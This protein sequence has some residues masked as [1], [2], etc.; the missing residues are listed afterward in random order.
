MAAR[1]VAASSS[2]V[3]VVGIPP[4]RSVQN[5]RAEI[6]TTNGEIARIQ[7]A[8]LPIDELE[9]SLRTSLAALI[10]PA[11][12]L[13]SRAAVLL[14]EGTRRVQAGDLIPAIDDVDLRANLALGFALRGIGVDTLVAEARQRA[15]LGASLRLS[16]GERESR[17][18]ELRR[19][20]YVLECEDV[21]FSEAAGIPL[22]ADTNPAAALGVPAEI[23]VKHGLL[24]E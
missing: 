14:A 15:D 20:R 16:R 23:A 9:S 22:R 24:G 18:G 11:D 13:I 2:P 1:A 8:A 17:I 4:E 5:V 7:N 12:R 3:P 6:A 10:E 19:A 21:R